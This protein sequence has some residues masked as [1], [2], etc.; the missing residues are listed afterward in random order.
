[1]GNLEIQLEENKTSFKPGEEI[2]GNVLW[3]FNGTPLPLEL[4]LFWRTEGRGTQDIGV[5]ETISIET[6]GA[7]GQKDF[8]FTAPTAP[9]S[10]CGKLISIIWALELAA[11]KGKDALQKDLVISP[12]GQKITCT[13]S[14]PGKKVHAPFS[15]GSNFK[16][17]SPTL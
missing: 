14:F 3:N 8:K 5:V 13:E 7:S 10:F 12:T 6:P 15:G 2:R 16:Q 1:M 11:T 4:S 9:Y 17:I